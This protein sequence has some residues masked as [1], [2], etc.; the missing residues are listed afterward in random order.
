MI[1]EFKTSR[2]AN[3]HRKYLCIDTDAMIYS[4]ESRRM[5]FDGFEVKA[6]DYKELIEKC[7][8]YEFKKVDYVY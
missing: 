4:T 7:K 2:N 3:G 1:L 8:R 6:S 5:V